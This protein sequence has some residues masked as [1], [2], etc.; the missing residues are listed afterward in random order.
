MK[1]R[2]DLHFDTAHSPAFVL[3]MLLYRLVKN[4]GPESQSVGV[5][6]IQSQKWEI[7][8][9]IHLGDHPIFS[10]C[11]L[12]MYEESK[13]FNCYYYFHRA[14]HHHLSPRRRLPL[15]GFRRKKSAE[16]EFVVSG[17]WVRECLTLKSQR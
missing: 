6:P 15:S 11:K 17:C 10:K 4:R 2:T 5:F 16:E 1:Y 14:L 12:W 9:V 13:R 8:W 3:S 7:R